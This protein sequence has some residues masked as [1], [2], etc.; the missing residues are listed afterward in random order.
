MKKLSS[1]LT[2]L[3]YA[4][5]ACAAIKANKNLPAA[6]IGLALDAEVT[7]I[8]LEIMLRSY[9]LEKCK[10][11]YISGHGGAW[12]TSCGKIYDADDFGCSSIRECPNCQRETTT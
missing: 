9:L 5:E 7:L 8:K 11:K 2:S 1:Q 3:E 10:W 6:R 4:K 12:E